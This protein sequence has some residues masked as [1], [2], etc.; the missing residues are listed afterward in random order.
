[1]TNMIVQ[2]DGALYT[3][4]GRLAP[5]DLDRPEIKSPGSKCEGRWPVTANDEHDR[6]A[7]WGFVH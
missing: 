7:R 3:E 2:S 1:M 5:S 4:T 6:P